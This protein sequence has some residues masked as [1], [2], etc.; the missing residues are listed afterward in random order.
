MLAVAVGVGGASASTF[1]Q[2]AAPRR[3]SSPALLLSIRGGDAETTSTE[4]SVSAAAD[5]EPSLD[6]KV[7][8]AMKKFG[9]PTPGSS[10]DN[11]S[12]GNNNDNCQDGV[13]IMPGSTTTTSSAATATSATDP[14]E[15]SEKLAKEFNVDDRLTM[16]AIGATS[17]LGDKNQRVYNEEAART[18]IQQELDLINRVGDDHPNVK[19]L[20]SEGYD[21]FMSRRALAFADENME[22]AR[23]ILLAEKMDEEEA[24]QAEEEEA[25]LA[26]LRAEQEAQKEEPKMDTVEVKANF[27]PTKLGSPPTPNAAAKQQSPGGMP[28]PAKKEAV[29]FEATTAQIQELVL[30]SPVPVLLDIYADWCGKSPFF[31]SD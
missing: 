13:C 1:L 29:V 3:V 30:E 19:Q 15:L 27:D 26:A 22:D 18:L 14:H 2:K 8:A 10:D 5:N 9:I 31:F 17:S 21:V 28:K 6:D 7:Y 25:A 23:A 20:V 12:G 11:P 4:S 16:A 24:A